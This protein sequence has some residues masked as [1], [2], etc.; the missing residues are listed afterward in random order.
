MEM[1][2]LEIA[3]LLGGELIGDGSVIIKDI[4]QI[5]NAKKGEISFIA[6]KKNFKYLSQTN[7]SAV[8][9]P[10]DVKDTDKNVIKAKNPYLSFIK[11]VQFFRP[12]VFPIK[13]CIDDK[14]IIGKNCIIEDGTA[15]GAYVVIEDD[16]IV[17][18]GA[19]IFPGVY[20][21]RKVKIDEDSIIY[22]NVSILRD[23]FIGKRVIIHSGTVIGSDGFGFIK[24]GERYVKVPHTGIV[25]IEDDVEIG[26]NCAVDRA[27]IG[28]TRIKKGCKLDNLIHIAH[29]VVVCENT[30]MAA[31][32]G[33]SGSTIIGKNVQIGGQAGFIHHLKIGD[34]VQVGAQA[35][36]IN[37]W[38]DNSAVWGT[39][40]K[41]LTE[42]KKLEIYI[43]KLPELFK[44]M[45]K[46]EKNKKGE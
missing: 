44:R 23:V 35:G 11:L 28:E 15:I 12:L 38:E 45:T 9:V 26:A 32:V 1:T 7:A 10:T 18:K 19:K 34:G 2:L 33:I 24:E 40:A 21:G 14:A 46:L 39:P 43:R 27:T 36:V 17:R 8:I 6:N 31:Q 30:V 37:S 29:N 3:N 22:P 16:V 4:A 5:E 41:K 25:V 42:T 20:I 13:I